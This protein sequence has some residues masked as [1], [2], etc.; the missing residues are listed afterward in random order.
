MFRSHA[1]LRSGALAEDAAARA[2]EDDGWTI[3]ARNVRTRSGEVDIVALRR[4]VIGFAEVKARKT[5]GAADEALSRAKL[6]QVA[7]VSEEIVASRGLSGR[8]RSY[9]G[10]AVDLDA[11]GAPA[12][13]RIINVEEIR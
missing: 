9:I 6:R 8:E 13:V 7:R 1:R 3:L 2:L 5:P 4:G 10:V 12:A 11:G